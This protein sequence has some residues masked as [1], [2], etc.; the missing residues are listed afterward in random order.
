MVTV[1]TADPGLTAALRALADPNRRRVLV[2]LRRRE[3]CVSVLADRLGIT[4][5]LVSHHLRVLVA[6]GFVHERH[7][8]SWRCY[9]LVPE[10]LAWIKEELAGLL[11][12][13]LPAEAGCCT[14]PCTGD[15]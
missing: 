5:A 6:G 15:R 8:G 7:R 10:H 11:D 14:N 9:S 12:P 4:T 3:E 1:E 13:D 2:E